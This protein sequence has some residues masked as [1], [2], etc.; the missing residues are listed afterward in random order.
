MFLFFFPQHESYRVIAV[1]TPLLKFPLTP[2]KG[3]RVSR[4]LRSATF[5]V[6]VTCA[7]T[8]FGATSTNYYVA[9]T[10]S[11][12]NP[13]TQSAPFRTIKKAASVVNP[14]TTVHVAPGTYAESIT[15]T[16]SGTVSARIR[17]VSDTKW[18]AKIVP[19]KNAITMWRVVGGYTDIDGFQ[20]DGTGGTSVRQ[21]IY[22]TG[23]N[24]SVRNSWIHNVAESSGCDSNG[25]GGVT[26][27]QHAGAQFDNYDITG[28]LIHHIGGTCHWIHGIYHASSGTIK[29][30]IVHNTNYGILAGHDPHDLEISNNTVFADNY[31]G[32]EYDGGCTERDT[33]TCPGNNINIFNNIIYDSAGGIGGPSAIEDIGNNSIKN[34]LIYRSGIYGNFQMGPNALSQVSGTM[35]ADPQFV[36]YIREGGGDYRLK[37]SSPAI[38][39]GAIN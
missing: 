28:N 15:S 14:G 3:F 35:S 29:N 23:G 13:G 7:L 32:I 8:V 27:D 17:Y 38:G 6:A 11:D 2:P 20:I 19:I 18:R 9:T 39:K 37:S 21:G 36:N 33:G 5:F 4:T 10:G 30:N 1:Q 22:M 16:M 31:T 24:S 34:N 12:A 25:G 26:V